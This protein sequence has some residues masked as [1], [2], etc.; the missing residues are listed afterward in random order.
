MTVK[1]DGECRNSASRR[2]S[3]LVTSARKL[4][5]AENYKTWVRH[6]VE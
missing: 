3:K 6:L 4:N 2:C 5:K 1:S